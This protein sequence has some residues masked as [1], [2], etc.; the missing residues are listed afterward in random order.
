[1]SSD[2]NGLSSRIRNCKLLASF[3]HFMYN[4]L[5]ISLYI[6]GRIRW[7][8]CLPSLILGKQIYGIV[9]HLL[10]QS[11]KT[12]IRMKILQA[13]YGWKCVTSCG[14]I[15]VTVYSKFYVFRQQTEGQKVL[16]WM[17]ASITGVRSPLNFLL[18]QVSI[19]Y[20]RSY[21]Y[22]HVIILWHLIL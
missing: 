22:I 9:S 1:M 11:R 13:K 10:R 8:I 20:R 15:K 12:K 5:R 21:V 3:F 16:D 6:N 2:R 14:Y 17:V 7:D 18:N 4:E 19:C